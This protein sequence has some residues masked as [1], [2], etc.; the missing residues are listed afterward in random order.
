MNLLVCMCTGSE[1]QRNAQT[2]LG[3]Q[4]GGGGPYMLHALQP[5]TSFGLTLESASWLC[6]QVP[7]PMLID[8]RQG[9]T[10]L[11]STRRV[12]DFLLGLRTSKLP[13]GRDPESR[14]H[15]DPKIMGK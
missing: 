14:L 5:G 10:L 4:E 9:S 7:L 13:P 11:G 6:I 3:L 2:S 12:L 15:Q 8:E 1:S